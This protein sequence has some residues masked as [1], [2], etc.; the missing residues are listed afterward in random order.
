VTN[1]D[2]T[3]FFSFHSYTI[4]AEKI[5]LPK[6]GNHSLTASQCFEGGSVIA[7]DVV[8]V[9]PQQE[10]EGGGCAVKLT[11]PQPLDR[12]PVAAWPQTER[13]EVKVKVKANVKAKEKVEAKV[14]VK[15]E[16]NS[17]VKVEVNSK[18]KV[19]LEVN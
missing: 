12:L 11:D 14:E 1:I 6:G 5:L 19:K 3:F 15:A 9:V 10:A 17:K 2:E 7:R 13:A 18:V 8:V 4:Q 16:V